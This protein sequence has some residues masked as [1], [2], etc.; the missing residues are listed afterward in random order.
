MMESAEV[1]AVQQSGLPIPLPI[2]VA[3]VVA[4]IAVAAVIISNKRKK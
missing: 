3:V 2:L 4:V 1:A